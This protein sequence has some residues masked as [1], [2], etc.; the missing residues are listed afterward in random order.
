LYSDNV[1]EEEVV[2]NRR[3]LK[4]GFT[5]A[6]VMIA[7]LILLII[8]F[9][10]MAG[11]IAALKVHANAADHYR[12][13]CIARNRI[14]QAKA[15]TFSGYAN[16]SE[17]QFRVDQNGELCTTGDYRR[18]TSTSNAGENCVSVTVDVWYFV[19]PQVWCTAPVTIQTMIHTS[20][21]L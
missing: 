9:G 16:I 7:S 15:L 8:S 3:M 17:A 6:E 12:A 2:S 18:S 14:Q 11:I 1:E 5:L 4:S 10:I 19:K 13:T 20:M 21:Q